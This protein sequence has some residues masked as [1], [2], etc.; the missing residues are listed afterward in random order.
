MAEHDLSDLVC[1]PE[2]IGRGGDGEG[3]FPQGGVLGLGDGGGE[4]V[5]ISGSV[6]S[7]W[8]SGVGGDWLGMRGQGYLGLCR[9]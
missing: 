7:E 6:G 2:E 5:G 1:G 8:G 4:K 3:S 9:W